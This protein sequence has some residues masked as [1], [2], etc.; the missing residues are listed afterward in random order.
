MIIEPV[1][2]LK[3]HPANSVRSFSRPEWLRQIQKLAND[4]D[5]FAAFDS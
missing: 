2:S 1:L 4:D 3:E 5:L